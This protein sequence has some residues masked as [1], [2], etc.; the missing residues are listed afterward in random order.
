[1]LALLSMAQII[2]ADGLLAPGAGFST[3]PGWRMRAA[4]SPRLRP[5]ST[6]SPRRAGRRDILL[7]YSGDGSAGRSTAVHIDLAR[8]G[9]T[10]VGSWQVFSLIAR[11]RCR[12]PY[13]ALRVRGV[14]SDFDG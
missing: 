9:V 10:G 6:Q 8:G 7:A 11:K 1:M 14:D 5:S 4:V 2:F 12:R 3:R 13:V